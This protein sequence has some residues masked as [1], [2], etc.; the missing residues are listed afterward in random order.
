VFQIKC[1]PP[2]LRLSVKGPEFSTLLTN[3]TDFNETVPTDTYR[4]HVRY[5]RWNEEADV[6][7]AANAT[8]AREFAPKF[9]ALDIT[10][11]KSGATF[12][13][14]R[15]ANER[16]IQSGTLP[17][18][19]SELPAGNYG[20]KISYRGQA[21]T[22]TVTVKFGL[23]NQIKTEFAFGTAIL[24]TRPA[25]AAVSDREGRY[26]GQTPLTL[27]ELQPGSW[28][29]QLKLPGYEPATT[30]LEIAA[31]ETQSFR[32]NLISF[33]YKSAMRAARDHMQTGD[34]DRALNAVGDALLAKPN[35]AEAM[36]LQREASGLAAI[37]KAKAL[38]SSGNYIE[39][40][41]LLAEALKAV[42]DNA[43]VMGLQTEYKKHE[44]EQLDRARQ[45]GLTRTKTLFD[46]IMAK[47][48]DA[49][50]F[51][52][53]EVKTAKP[54]KDLQLAI[55][56]ALQ[57][58]QPPL[59]VVRSTTPRPETFFIEAVQEF[60]TALAT[61][62]GRRHCFIVGGQTKDDE[63]QILYKVLEYKTEAVNKFSLG[64]L[65]G[66]PAA[67]NYV[68]LHA[69]RVQMTEALKTRVQEGT[70]LISDRIQRAVGQ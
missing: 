33:G 56:H 7:V 58:G 53:Q 47:S 40:G 9:G 54:A 49:A 63:T 70:K 39:A 42:P 3:A 51:E 29:F 41:T 4:V 36:E 14:L 68:P 16:A 17:V 18:V 52:T 59:K 21:K 19:I 13:L 61:S 10:C 32:T 46:S 24:E 37:K 60:S 43:E 45:E 65:I 48:P 66:A 27:S 5:T 67:V 6:L 20:L 15:K 69:S 34:Y 11:N 44:A 62:A 57:N 38:A 55:N 31:N 22:E 30:T 50:L 26:L 1:D 2:A 28:T 8:T 12:E 25:E 23:T 35:D 64:N